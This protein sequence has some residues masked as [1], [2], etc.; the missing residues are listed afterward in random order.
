MKFTVTL[1]PIGKW[2]K[3]IELLKGTRSFSYTIRSEFA[4]AQRSGNILRLTG[5]RP[6][7]VG[8]EPESAREIALECARDLLNDT[9]QGFTYDDNGTLAFSE[10]DTLTLQSGMEGRRLNRRQR[11]R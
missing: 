8:A 11:S 2:I 1:T 3:W 10:G 4:D 9:S 5:G 7:I 6:Q